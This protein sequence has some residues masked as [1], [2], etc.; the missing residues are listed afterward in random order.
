MDVPKV[1]S[2]IYMEFNSDEGKSFVVFQDGVLQ[3]N[4]TGISLVHTRDEYGV[5][6][7]REIGFTE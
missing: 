7:E 2:L 4:I 5:D 3:E 1:P 6:F